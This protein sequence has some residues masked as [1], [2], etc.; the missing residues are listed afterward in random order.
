MNTRI[1]KQNQV[2]VIHETST[3]VLSVGIISAALVGIW[4]VICLISAL[5][6]NGPVNLVK[7]YISTI[8]GS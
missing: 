5:S 7:G 3:F 4:G 2:D 6:S 1:E 8:I